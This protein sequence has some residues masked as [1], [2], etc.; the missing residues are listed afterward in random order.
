MSKAITGNFIR[1]DGSPA[2]CALL[3]LRLSQDGTAADG[4]GQIGHYPVIVTLDANGQIP[5]IGSVEGLL[6]EANDE[7]LPAGTYYV[8][9]VV[10]PIFGRIYFERLMIAGISPINVN[11]IAP[12]LQ[13]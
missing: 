1:P 7:I 10:D 4:S 11:E 9:S 13:Q 3:T 8:V 2:A 6:I 5:V 12:S